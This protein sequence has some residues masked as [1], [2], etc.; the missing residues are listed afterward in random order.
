MKNKKDCIHVKT[1]DAAE[2]MVLMNGG[3]DFY[4]E[5]EMATVSI[6]PED[7]KYKKSS[8]SDLLKPQKR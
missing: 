6:K 4:I 7:I 8:D 5:D 3:L 2:F 1:R